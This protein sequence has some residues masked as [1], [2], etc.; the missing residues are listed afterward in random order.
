VAETGR[1]PD[2]FS[3]SLQVDKDAAKESRPGSWVILEKSGTRPVEGADSP[4][5]DRIFVLGYDKDRQ[6]HYTAYRS[7]DINGRLPLRVEGQGDAKT[8]IVKIKTDDG[9]M[10]DINSRRTLIAAG[11]SR[12]KLATNYP[13][14]Q[15]RSDAFRPILHDPENILQGWLT[16]SRLCL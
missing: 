11:F 2:D 3:N 15:S 7:P 10:K 9:S 6:E 12:S 14:L 13:K 5:F 8:F 1:R 16:N 4:D